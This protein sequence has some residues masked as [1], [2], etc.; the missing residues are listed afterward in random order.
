M[1]RD[2]ELLSR[3]YNVTHGDLEGTSFTLPQFR[4]ILESMTMVR[5]SR[6]ARFW[7]NEKDED[8]N[9]FKQS[10][11]DLVSGFYGQ[12]CP[13]ILLIIGS[14]TQI[15]CWFGASSKIMDGTA[16]RFNLRGVFRDLRFGKSVSSQ[17]IKLDS[18]KHA[19]VLTGI[20]SP[21]AD[22]KGNAKNDQIEKLCRG[23]FGTNW[24]YAVYAESM[25][26]PE[27]IQR[28]ND[29]S[30][31]IR[32]VQTTFLLKGSAIDEQDRTAKR[33]IE[34]LELKLKR[35]EQG[36]V[37]GMWNA[38]TMIFTENV[39]TLGRAQALLY[40]AFS[41]EMSSP[42]P[43]RVHPCHASRRENVHMEP[44]NSKE[45]SVFAAPPQEEYPGFELIDYARYGVEAGS[46]A[47]QN[48][49]ILQIGNIIDGGIETGN[50]FI[51]PQQDLTKHGLIVGVTGSGK[52]NTC[53]VL[54]D[55][56]WD[57]GK[58]IPFLVIESAKS[59]YRDL[60]TNPRF[61][62]LKVFTVGDETISPLRLN[63]FEVSTGISVQMHIDYLKSLFSAAFVLYPPMPYVLEQSIQEI[64][65][66]RGWDLAR[67][68]NYRGTDSE[69]LFPTISDLA[70]KVEVI[71]K[72]MGY[73]ER[74]TMDVKAGLLARINQLRLGGG[75]GLMFNTRKSID[76]SILF[77]SPCILELKQVV[78]DDEKAF[79]MGLL[80]I[81]LYEYYESTPRNNKNRLG[82]VTLIEEAH[83]LLRNVSTDQ[84]SEVSA[85]PQGRAI[86]VF[87]NILSEIRAYGESI[88]MAE[89][90]PTKLTPDAIKNTNL[91]LVHRLVAEDDRTL[92]GNTMNLS[93]SQIRSLSILEA[94]Q[95]VS[96]TEGMNKPVLVTIPLSTTK[97]S[98]SK[99]ITSKEL[100]KSMNSFWI[101]NQ[102]LLFPYS[103][104]ENCWKDDSDHANCGINKYIGTEPNLIESFTRF[105]NTLRLNKAL[106]FNSYLEFENLK[107][108]SPHFKSSKN[109]IYCIL[110]E[111]T[112]SHIERLGEFWGWPFQDVQMAIDL[113]SNIVLILTRNVGQSERK[114]VEQE[115]SKLLTTFVNLLKRLHKIERLPYAGCRYCSEPCH[116]RFDLTC[117]KEDSH[118]RQL[119]SAYFNKEAGAHELLSFL[120]R[121]CWDKTS[122][123]FHAT[124]FR[125]RNNAALCF[126]IQQFNEIGLSRA[127]QED[128]TSQ[129]A[130]SINQIVKQKQSKVVG[131]S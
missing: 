51:I 110:I 37:S 33:L 50:S 48:S 27:I 34:L 119:Q 8:S 121:L 123:F 92:V 117:S 127:N 4:S 89:Q 46:S 64:Y 47:L 11:E 124:D 90:I 108:Q 122:S 18:F 16:L 36:R 130:D 3:I 80:L 70:A 94:G 109:A 59:E 84:S 81:K 113:I 7:Q 98:T 31:Q 128:M 82:H 25:P 42:V 58:G 86:E 83:R 57:G 15:E 91:K 105:F 54:L 103:G 67:N 88:L 45:A 66:D 23:L 60:L 61:K 10:V 71:V 2:A 40:S 39:L 30:T 131:K 49:K 95:S 72:R 26:N 129:I 112:D 52:T 116:Y 1:N 120:A 85:N 118:V 65:Q 78:S 32:N 93:E 38:I 20:P 44:L 35:Y 102:K 12:A 96:F 13:W 125:S 79:I 17:R 99:E 19:A 9:I 22:S 21:K 115:F 75:K 77:G 6:L 106:V 55:Q 87:A 111:L 62:G 107:R 28:I 97:K 101:Q 53:F 5:I 24:M 100:H 114:L 41:G 104:C 76:S 63:P 69:R 126:A 29:I 56:I 14:T 73:D 68:T 43:L 74:I